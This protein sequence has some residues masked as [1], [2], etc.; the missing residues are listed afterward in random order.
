MFSNNNI[1]KK[2]CSNLLFLG[3]EHS[4][5]SRS[6]ANDSLPSINSTLALFLCLPLKLGINDH[7]QITLHRI[8]MDAPCCHHQQLFFLF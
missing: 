8:R 3:I 4:C 7:I 1:N 6:P 2:A 5:T